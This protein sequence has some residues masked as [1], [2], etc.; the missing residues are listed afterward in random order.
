MS[1]GKWYPSTSAI[2]FRE[3][4]FKIIVPVIGGVMVY[5]RDSGLPEGIVDGR[6][7]DLPYRGCDIETNEASEDD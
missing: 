6:V 7:K 2:P 1:E 5:D 4:C 3:K